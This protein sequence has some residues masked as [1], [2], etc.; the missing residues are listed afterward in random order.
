MR[1][2]FNTVC[3]S[4]QLLFD[5][6]KKAKGQDLIVLN[7]FAAKSGHSFTPADIEALLLEKGETM[8]LTSIRRSISSLTDRGYLIKTGDKKPGK[9]NRNNFKWTYNNGH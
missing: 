7:V 9:W 1:S 3:E 2:Y 5:F 6:E 4:G 8:L